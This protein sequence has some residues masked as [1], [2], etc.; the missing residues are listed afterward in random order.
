MCGQTTLGESLRVCQ[1]RFI[2]FK[3]SLL[4]V[5]KENVTVE[6]YRTIKVMK[7]F[8]ARGYKEVNYLELYLCLVVDQSQRTQKELL[9]WKH[10]LQECCRLTSGAILGM[11]PLCD[12]EH[13]GLK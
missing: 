2:K 6:T 9:R 4:L 5:H 7:R 10:Y 8:D 13:L 1:S 3:F 12:L 11:L